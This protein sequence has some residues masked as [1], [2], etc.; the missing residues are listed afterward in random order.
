ML[1]YN[2]VKVLEYDVIVLQILCSTICGKC[3]NSTL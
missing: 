1:M 3:N 2:L